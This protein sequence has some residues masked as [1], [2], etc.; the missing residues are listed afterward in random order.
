M[1]VL[2]LR[3]SL[4]TCAL[5]ACLAGPVCA[6]TPIEELRVEVESLRKE[7]NQRSEAPAANL[8]INDLLNNKYGPNA[9]VSTRAGKLQ[10][11]GL[12][13]VWF[14]SIAND[15]VGIVTSA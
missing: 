15:H 6:A 3:V 5:F 10:I 4:R 14:Q 2:M 12:I 13:Q 9:E 8:K 1:E 11:G 7:I